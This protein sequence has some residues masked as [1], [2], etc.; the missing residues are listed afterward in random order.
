MTSWTKR[1]GNCHR[2]V[3]SVLGN[4]VKPDMVFLNLSLEEFPWRESDL[5][6]DLVELSRVH[7]EFKIHWVHGPN[8]KPW[9][10]VFPI[11]DY[12]A[13]DDLIIL[14]DDDMN[15]RRDLVETR[16]REFDQ[17]NG[18]FAISGGACFPRSHLNVPISDYALY[19]TICPTSIL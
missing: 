18:Q 12:L 16:V 7:P 9:K 6:K 5:P 3:K 15:I 10:K 1:I 4:T 19:N 8:V 11:L 14:I 13:D 2:I 17:Y